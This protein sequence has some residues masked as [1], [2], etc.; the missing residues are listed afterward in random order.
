MTNTNATT[1]YRLTVIVFTHRNGDA[2]DHFNV[3]IDELDR[4]A[5]KEWEYTL[6]EW[7]DNA[8]VAMWGDNVPYLVEKVA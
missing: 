5:M 8:A 2:R 6:E 4:F 1:T 7:L 3:T